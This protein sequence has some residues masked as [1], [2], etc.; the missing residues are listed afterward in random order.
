MA[1][2]HSFEAVAPLS[3]TEAPAHWL[4]TAHTHNNPLVRSSSTSCVHIYMYT[5]TYRNMSLLIWCWVWGGTFIDGLLFLSK[6]AHI[7]AKSTSFVYISWGYVPSNLWS[8]MLTT[9]PGFRSLWFFVCRNDQQGP[10][11]SLNVELHRKQWWHKLNKQVKMSWRV[12]TA[13]PFDEIRVIRS[14]SKINCSAT[15]DELQ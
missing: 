1:A 3:A 8:T 2:V 4:H 10:R 15:G 5:R 14:N 12:C 11:N 9:L 7:N 13:H 6:D